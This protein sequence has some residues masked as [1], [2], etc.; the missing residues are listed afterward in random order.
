MDSFFAWLLCFSNCFYAYLALVCVCVCTHCALLTLFM[1]PAKQHS[2][3]CPASNLPR[4]PAPM[5]V[6][7]KALPLTASCLS[8]LPGFESKSGCV[9]RLPVTWG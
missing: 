7:S 6:W 9:R 8:P 3:H 5:A 4:R 1:L 2:N